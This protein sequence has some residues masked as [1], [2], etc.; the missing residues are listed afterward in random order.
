MNYIFLFFVIFLSSCSLDKNSNYWTSDSIKKN[1]QKNKLTKIL[2]KS[3]NL[4]DLSID[5][6]SH[7]LN[8]YSN[9]SNFPDINN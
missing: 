9:R 7:Y 5:E 6:F 1:I 2:N 3:T 4:L 8:D